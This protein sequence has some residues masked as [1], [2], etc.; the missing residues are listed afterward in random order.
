MTQINCLACPS[1]LTAPDTVTANE[2]A[3]T[4]NWLSV[5]INGVDGYLCERCGMWVDYPIRIWRHREPEYF[6]IGRRPIQF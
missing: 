4:N 2:L 5:K 3:A 6:E 1:L